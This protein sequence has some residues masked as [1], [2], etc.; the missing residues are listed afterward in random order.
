MPDQDS[1][2]RTLGHLPQHP[3]RY[4]LNN[5]VH[6]RPPVSLTHPQRVSYLALIHDGTTED[7]ELKQLRALADAFARPLPEADGGHL[8]LDV[9]DFLLKWERHNEFSSYAFFCTP[10]ADETD[11]RHGALPRVPPGWLEG[12]PGSVIV[13]THIELQS[14]TAL[15][16]KSVMD[17]LIAS[18]RQGVAAQVADGA[19]WVFTDFMLTDGWSRYLVLDERLTPRQAGR[20]VQRLLEIE[21]YRVM[22]LLA[23][24]VAKDVGRL[25]GRAEGELADLMDSMGTAT[26]PEDERNVLSHLTRLAAEVERSVART[27]FRFGAAQAYYRL[28]TSR[29]GELREQRVESFPTIGEFMDRRL[30]P[31]INTCEAIARRQEELSGRIARNSQ[32]LRTRVDIELERQNQELLVQMN[33]RAKLQM[34]LQETVE[35]L[36]IVAITYYASQLVQYLAKGLHVWLPLSPDTITAISIPVIAGLAALGLR[37]MRRKLAAEEGTH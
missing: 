11:A 32:L 17:G 26:T 35:G 37:R 15:G 7:S 16:P 33:R 22:A 34:R 12:L 29:I 13:A 10:R 8:Q 28:V 6:A 24:P 21:T 9:G 25:L 30:A 36:S 31:A 23:F 27:T 14:T 4:K 19:A 1:P 5:E 18:G 2:A 20:T 3:L